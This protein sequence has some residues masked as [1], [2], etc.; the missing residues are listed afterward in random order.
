LE[1]NRSI[2]DASVDFCLACVPEVAKNARWD[3]PFLC[4]FVTETQRVR[5]VKLR[6]EGAGFVAT[7]RPALNVTLTRETRR[8]FPLSLFRC[9]CRL[10]GLPARDGHGAPVR[11][12]RSGGN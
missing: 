5:V 2:V 6:I 3:Q 7:A 8:G 9:W 12:R 4:R 10:D 1:L 11:R